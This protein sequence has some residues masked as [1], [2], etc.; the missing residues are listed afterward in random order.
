MPYSYLVAAL[1]F[2]LCNVGAY[3]YGRSDGK[4]IEAASQ[5][6]EARVVQ[7]ATDA[8]NKTTAAAIAKIEVKQV[9]IRQRVEKEIYEKPIYRECRHSD[10][11]LRDINQALTN[12]AKP[13]S[14]SELPVSDSAR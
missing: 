11:V 5:M 9:T 4:E 1:A 8:A 7:I 3:F 13:A 2:V 10:V 6:R 14:D 12:G